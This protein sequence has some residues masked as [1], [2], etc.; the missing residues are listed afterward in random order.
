MAE[1][2]GGLLR[3]NWS[4]MKSYRSGSNPT[5]LVAL[6]EEKDPS[7]SPSTRTE[8]KPRARTVRTQSPWKPGW[9]PRQSLTTLE[10]T[11]AERKVYFGHCHMCRYTRMNFKINQGDQVGCLTWAS[12]SYSCQVLYRYTEIWGGTQT[13]WKMGL[14]KRLLYGL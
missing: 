13:I 9:S 2:R 7:L 14:W 12:E 11:K 10:Q 3:S 8:E 5:G 6:E 1:F 4:W